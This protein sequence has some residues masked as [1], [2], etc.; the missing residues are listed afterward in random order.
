MTLQVS[1]HRGWPAASVSAPSRDLREG[2]AAG[3]F[4][5]GDFFDREFRHPTIQAVLINRYRAKADT[6]WPFPEIEDF[7][8]HRYKYAIGCAQ[9]RP[10]GLK[11]F[12][13]SPVTIGRLPLR[14]VRYP[15][16]SV[17]LIP[18][19]DL[20]VAVQIICRLSKHTHDMVRKV[21][22]RLAD[23][24][25]VLRPD[26][27][28]DVDVV[29]PNRYLI[30]ANMTP[31]GYPGIQILNPLL[32]SAIERG[33]VREAWNEDC[34]DDWPDHRRLYHFASLFPVANLVTA[35]MPRVTIFDGKLAGDTLATAYRDAASRVS[36]YLGKPACEVCWN[37][38]EPPNTVRCRECRQKLGGEKF[39]RLL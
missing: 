20:V 23:Q 26:Y 16:G 38:L 6:N 5:P 7:L 39:P 22:D 19:P 17:D 35:F 3:K 9:P 31:S 10:E 32:D 13:Q 15:E 28:A 25:G 11:D 1:L 8:H 24:V 4:E 12:L 29:D 37:P 33:L 21:M 2:F 27:L 14:N 36:D 30:L 34:L 18:E